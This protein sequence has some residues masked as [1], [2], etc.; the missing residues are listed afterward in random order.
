MMQSLLLDESW[1]ALGAISGTTLV[2]A[3]AVLFGLT[4]LFA[5]MLG[6]AKEKLKVI[7][8]PRIGQVTEALPAANCGGC[9]FAG[10][11][12]FA[13]AVVE[14]RAACD[15]C[16]VGG[17]AV[18][19]KV[20]EILGIEVVESFPCR[21]I[22]HCSARTHQK[23]GIVPYE[24]VQSCVEADVVGVTQGCIYGC[25][26]FG[27]CVKICNYGAL[28]MEEGLPIFDYDKC[29]GCGA[30]VKACPRGIIE[31][32]PFQQD[33][34]L[35]IACSNKEPARLVKQVC[36]VGCVGCKMCQK[37]LADMF[38]VRNNLAY[39]KYDGYAAEQEREKIIAKCPA[40]AMVYFGKPKPEYAEMLAQQSA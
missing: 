4:L 22:L 16:P 34:M 30:C 39:I 19:A 9:G 6:V 11:A 28:R 18:A 37:M 3:A 38:E 21:P 2:L 20:A 29:T 1:T 13:K 35:V 12:D 7:E 32:I 26:G 10:C 33:R 5:G 8:D 25:L 14:Q 31:Q 40:E 23:K 17:S 27:D 36:E 15:G 24:G